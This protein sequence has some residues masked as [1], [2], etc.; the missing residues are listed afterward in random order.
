MF[1]KCDYYKIETGTYFAINKICVD[2]I[3]FNVSEWKT[4]MGYP[5][6]KQTT[7]SES[8]YA[9]KYVKKTIM[10]ITKDVLC[11]AKTQHSWLATQTA[12]VDNKREAMQHVMQYWM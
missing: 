10:V 6:L 11:K 3:T 1:E 7:S 2:Y 4:T 8:F 9:Q 5:L 12:D